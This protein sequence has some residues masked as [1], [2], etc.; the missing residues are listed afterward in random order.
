MSL[1]ALSLPLP[2]PSTIPS[3]PPPVHHPLAS[4]SRPPSHPASTPLAI[5]ITDPSAKSAKVANT[6]KAHRLEALAQ[7]KGDAVN[8]AVGKDLMKAYQVDGIAPN[9]PDMLAKVALEHGLFESTEQAKEWISS[10]ALNDETQA[11]YRKARNEGITGVPF[12][13]FDDKFA[14]SGAVGVEEFYG[15]IDRIMDA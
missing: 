6:N 2:F 5:G 1:A 3:P 11:G 12:F 8:Y 15:M 13:V 9:D 10:D 7:A 14:A 4:T